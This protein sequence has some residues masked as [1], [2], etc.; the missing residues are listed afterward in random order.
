LSEGRVDPG[1]VVQVAFA[2]LNY[3]EVGGSRRAVSRPFP[4]SMEG[5]DRKKRTAQNGPLLHSRL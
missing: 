4:I 5:V 1:I 2:H 3:T